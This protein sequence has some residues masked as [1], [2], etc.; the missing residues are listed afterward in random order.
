MRSV[1]AH[2]LQL[3]D[4][5]SLYLLG[6]NSSSFPL[7][8]R[9]RQ[10]MESCSKE[11]EFLSFETSAEWLSCYERDAQPLHAKLPLLVFRPYGGD[12]IAPFMKVCYQMA[13]PVTVRCGGTGFAGS[14]VPS[15]E[16][17][18]ILT[19]HLHKIRNYDR[20]SGQLCI[21]PG[22]T[23][24]QLNRFVEKDGWNFPLSM[25]TEGVAG[26]AGCLSCQARGYH[27]Q[28]QA[29]YDSIVE[30]I[31]VDGQGE[32]LEAPA[33]LV[34]GAEGLFGVIIEMKMCLKKH[35]PH[36]REFIYH[37]SWQTILDQLPLLC[38]LDTLNIA[39]WFQDRFYLRLEGESWRMPAAAAYV[40]K[41]L[42]EIQS[43]NVPVEEMSMKFLPSHQNFIVI[44]SVVNPKLLP[45]ACQWSLRQAHHLQLECLQ[46]ADLLSGSIH[47]IL[48]ARD[49]RYLFSQKI[50]QFLVLWAD[51]IDQL[52]GGL[53]TCHGVGMQMHPYMTPFWSEESQSIWRN[54]QRL[55]DPKQLFGKERFFPSMGKSLE[56]RRSE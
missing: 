46:N 18:V 21:E 54:L 24:R 47:L 43:R 38:S 40:T 10:L 50:E 26:I 28:Q 8:Q 20:T 37:G 4:S 14:C 23:I 53:T 49:N 55:F 3:D 1:N 56:K 9:Y 17:V 35:L 31:L 30:V 41:C 32:I 11:G 44:S 19:G 48:Q 5:R 7:F 51:F 42:P 33:S 52:Q 29:F 22:V 36:C 15:S 45:E 16:G 25:A 39:T 34:C 2:S 13:L 12:N 6:Q 27:Q